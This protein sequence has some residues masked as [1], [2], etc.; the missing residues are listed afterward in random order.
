MTTSF[1]AGSAL[2]RYNELDWIQQHDEIPDRIISLNT[3]SHWF[4]AALDR[5]QD[6]GAPGPQATLNRLAL[7][8]AI[9][10]QVLREQAGMAHAAMRN[11]ATW[12]EVARALH[13]TTSQARQLV[14][15]HALKMH[16]ID[17][18]DERKGRRPAGYAEAN[19]EA[20]KDLLRL[21]NDERRAPA[22]QSRG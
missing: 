11:G 20:V 14:Q 17:T 9:V 10:D 4:E 12:W 3:L 16:S 21:N 6:P 8:A 15:D 5:V 13:I 2:S 7:G 1:P 19:L 18:H 22:E